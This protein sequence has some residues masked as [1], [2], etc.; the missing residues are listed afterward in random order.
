MTASVCQRIAAVASRL[1]TERG[2]IPIVVPP[3]VE[4]GTL[5]RLIGPTVATL[6]ALRVAA[7]LLADAPLRERIRDA[8]NAYRCGVSHAP[9]GEQALAIVTVGVS[10]ES[11]NAHRWKLLEALLSCDPPVWDVLQFAHGPLQAFHER[12]LTLLVLERGH[13]SPLVARLEAT[14]NPELHRVIHVASEHDDELAFFEHAAA[15]DG[16]LLASLEAR[17]RDLFDWPARHGDAPLYGV[18]GP[19]A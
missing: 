8:P 10:S 5:V 3:S 17:P 13:G 7:L 4:H 2:F 14:L 19:T 18:G 1:F 11:A 6:A 9:L 12:R 15:I 16:L